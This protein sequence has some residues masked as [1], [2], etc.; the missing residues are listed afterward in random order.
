MA[1]AA[2]GQQHVEDCSVVFLVCGRL[3]A[4]NDAAKIFSKAPQEIRDKVVPMIHNFYD[5]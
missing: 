1:E 4:Y 2:W 5:G 3:D